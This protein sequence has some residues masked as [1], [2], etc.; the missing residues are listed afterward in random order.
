MTM[1]V[2]KPATC[3]GKI[4]SLAQPNWIVRDG[5]DVMIGVGGRTSVGGK[6][7]GTGWVG[8]GVLLGWGGAS[9]TGCDSRRLGLVGDMLGS[10]MASSVTGSIGVPGVV[11][12]VV[13][14]SLVGGSGGQ[15][16]KEKYAPAAMKAITRHTRRPIIRA[17]RF[18]GW[19]GKIGGGA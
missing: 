6:V 15:N 18:R 3:A 10:R 16:L 4:S 7:G 1:D 11:T 9:D 12:N 8:R 13:I 2:Y 14:G 17:R 5:V 19:D